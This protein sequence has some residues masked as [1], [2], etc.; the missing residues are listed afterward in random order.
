MF[1]NVPGYDATAG[2]LGWYQFSQN[3]S[4]CSP[5]GASSGQ[6]FPNCNNPANIIALMAGDQT[7]ANNV[8]WWTGAITNYNPGKIKYWTSGLTP[9]RVFNILYENLTWEKACEIEIDL[10]KKLGRRDKKLGPLVNM[11]DGGEGVLGFIH[12]EETR[13]ILSIRNSKLIECPHC[14]LVGGY[15][16]MK[17][18]HFDNCKITTG[19]NKHKGHNHSKETKENI[20][21]SNSISQLGKKHTSDTIDKMRGPRDPYKLS[22]DKKNNI[23]EL[24]KENTIEEISKILNLSFP[25]ILQFLKDCGLYSR[26][27]KNKICPHCN[28]IGSGSNM[29]RYHF[30]NCKLKN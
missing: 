21:K 27:R 11:T 2:N 13:E 4:N 3:A 18:Y 8:S 16:N 22:E 23:K 9:T 10:I 6:V 28:L 17:R 7:F 25:T 30:D 1:G 20:G 26:K 5:A 24:Y 19:K 12:S 29:K 15:I 14:K